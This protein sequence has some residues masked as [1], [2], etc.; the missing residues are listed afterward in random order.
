MAAIIAAVAV[1]VG[2]VAGAVGY[3]I[4]YNRGDR[5]GTKNAEKT[6]RTSGIE[7]AVYDETPGG[8]ADGF[9]FAETNRGG[10]SSRPEGY[11]EIA[12]K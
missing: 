3:K 6:G 5:V 2:L 9:G 1:A 11:L 12:A 4:G 7:N 10:G 8:K